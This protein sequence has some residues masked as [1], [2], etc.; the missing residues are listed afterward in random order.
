MTTSLNPAKIIMLELVP[1]DIHQNLTVSLLPA[2]S[3]IFILAKQGLAGRVE[4]AG[5]GLDWLSGLVCEK[6]KK[7]NIQ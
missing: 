1:P 7:L 3:G 2:M 4:S 6:N 5:T